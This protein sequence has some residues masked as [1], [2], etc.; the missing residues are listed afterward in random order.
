MSSGFINKYKTL[1]LF[2][3]KTIWTSVYFII[4][5]IKFIKL[6]SIVLKTA[7]VFSSRIFFHYNKYG[8][9]IIKFTLKK[10]TRNLETILITG[11][12]DKL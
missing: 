4:S 3:F 2:H 12:Q 8:K 9:Y 1:S 11:V 5:F 7:L 6:N 10:R